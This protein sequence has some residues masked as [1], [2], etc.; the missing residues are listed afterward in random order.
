MPQYFLKIS[1]VGKRYHGWQIQDN[2]HTVQAEVNSA[3][4]GIVGKEIESIGC[5]RTDTGVHA[6]EFLLHFFIDEPL[7][8]NFLFQLNG[9]FPRDIAAHNLYH[10]HD[11]AHA[12]YDAVKR[13]YKYYIHRSKDPFLNGFSCFF[14]RQLDINSLNKAAEYLKEYRT[15]TSFSKKSTKEENNECTIYDAKWE[16]KGHQLIFTISANRFLRNMVRD[17]TGTIL[18][19]GTQERESGYIREVIEKKDRKAAGASVPSQGLY[20][21]NVEYPYELERYEVGKEQGEDHRA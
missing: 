4:S 18:E 20:L 2:A 1:F 15:F 11:D 16:E 9:A 10:M 7:T 12:R 19:I 14:P 5:G 13:T 21:T 6:K 8:S 3:I 17:I